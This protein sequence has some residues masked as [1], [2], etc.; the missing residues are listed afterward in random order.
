MRRAGVVA[1]A[2]V[3]I[4]LIAALWGLRRGG[5]AAS[6]AHPALDH[7]G[8][9]AI[10]SGRS[11]DPR[12]GPPASIS[13][14]ITDEAK[15]PIARAS[16]CAR[17]DGS[18]LPT[19]I[20]QRPACAV[21]DGKGQYKIANLVAADYVLLAGA[22][23]YPAAAFAPPPGARK[24]SFAL[25][26]GE[27]R[28]GVDVVLRRGGVEVT[29]VV[30]DISGGTI[31]HAQV[32]ALSRQL[33]GMGPVFEADDQGRFSLWV[34]RGGVGIEARADGYAANDVWGS[35]PGTFEIALTP[36]SSIAG[37]VVDAATDQPVP[38]ARVVLEASTFERRKGE[39]DITDAQ[40][41]FRLDGLMPGRFTAVATADRGYGRSEGST[42]VGLG[43]HVG[44]V[45]VKLHPAYRIE[46]RI[47][48]GA[49]QQP[50]PDGG[51]SLSDRV[52]VRRLGAL[53]EAE[54]SVVVRGVLPGTYDIVV[55]CER[56]WD[57]TGEPITVRDA[58]VTG[59]VWRIDE[60]AR[61]R[62]KVVTRSGDAAGGARLYAHNVGGTA[63]DSEHRVAADSEPDGSYELTGLRPG[64]Y[65]IEVSSL[66]GVAPR[67][68][69]TVPVAGAATVE[70]DLVL[71]DGGTVTGAVVDQDGAPVPAVPV[72]ARSDD[73]SFSIGDNGATTDARGAFTIAAL[74]PG[75]YVV[76]PR[77]ELRM[78]GKKSLFE[79]EKVTVRAG[80]TATV[81]LVVESA[82]GTI[83]GTVVD[84]AGAPVADAFVSSARDHESGVSG[85][86]S[87]ERTRSSSL[88]EGELVLTS[89]DGRFT[90][91]RLGPGTYAV[92]AHRR[93]GGEAFAEGVAV[94]ATVKL[95]IKPTGSI[96]GTVR[97][98]GSPVLDLVAS[99]HDKKSGFRRSETFY[100][101]DG[102]FKLD[103]LPAGR[104]QVGASADGGNKATTVDLAEGET[105]TGVDLSLETLVSVTG[106]L[107]DQA[108]KPI[109]R[110]RVYAYPANADVSSISVGGD[111]GP[112]NITD[113]SGKFTVMRIR[114]GQ[115]VLGGFSMAGPSSD[116]DTFEVARTV[117]G[118][119]TVD[120]GEVRV[121]RP[122]IKRGEPR[123]KLGVRFV[124]EP[125]DDTP[126]NDE[127]KVK[128]IVP[129]SPAARS[130]LQVGDVITTCDGL[131]VTG[132]NTR[133]FWTVMQAPPGTKVTLGTRRGVT[134][135]A[136]LAA[137]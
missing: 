121:A 23:N 10:A 116:F 51:V 78:P 105:R 124:E 13:G 66:H 36:E 25:A 31:A 56:R 115:I 15:A 99:V 8:A 113:E 32:R 48:L 79:G 80:E 128:E 38:G 43:Q 83:A 123:G 3:G 69:Y 104:Y 106:R 63:R 72:T 35:A 97:S 28:T 45:V 11:G 103:G 119:G 67:D 114:P 73:R 118:S 90:L 135:T 89:G 85:T 18:Q 1:V 6:P 107:V 74:R 34:D 87:V 108:Q 65:R 46:G 68:G 70:Q 33:R 44:G 30:R 120:L 131:D 112:A 9:R 81:K 98:N 47:V 60:G 134:V 117:A 126:A 100:R 19:A 94:G 64:A 14:A 50:C 29:G 24:L 16:V 42:L 88:G 20:T 7:R 92:R 12:S 62:G 109:P 82:N 59:V 26:A 5:D 4:A 37:R 49:G 132:V 86:S 102:R 110:V 39:T 84:A 57:N 91:N 41:A 71:E 53:S 77:S 27:A 125:D 52:H 22:P 101:T 130:A 21:S 54:G 2:V 75:D 40:G 111:D 129:G 61:I 17:T 122:R 93:G 96:E 136:I 55:G 127:L 58:D 76:S 133:D 137:P 95:Q